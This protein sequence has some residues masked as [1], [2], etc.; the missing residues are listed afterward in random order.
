MNP[1]NLILILCHACKIPQ[2]KVFRGR[3]DLSC[4]SHCGLGGIILAAGEG[5]SDVPVLIPHS[6]C[7]SQCCA[8]SW[9]QGR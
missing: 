4:T 9:L 3:M 7:I 8:L 1:N 5:V 6:P 2:R